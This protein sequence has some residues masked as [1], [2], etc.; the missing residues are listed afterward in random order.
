MDILLKKNNK[1]NFSHKIVFLAS[2][3]L[4][5]FF[6]LIQKIVIVVFS[7]KK[8]GSVI[9]PVVILIYLLFYF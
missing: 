7:S 1:N 9:F 4:Y 6:K 3:S 8:S 5:I 2:F